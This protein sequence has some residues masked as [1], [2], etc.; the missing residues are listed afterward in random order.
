[1]S[2]REI[3]LW[4]EYREEVEELNR[5]KRKTIRFVAPSQYAS[6]EEITPSYVGFMDWLTQKYEKGELE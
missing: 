4:R 6:L 3:K 5:L 2:I 1:M